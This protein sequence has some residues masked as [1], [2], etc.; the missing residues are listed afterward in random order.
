[1][2]R[3]LTATQ[4][5][6]GFELLPE[7]SVLIL[8]KN[9]IVIDVVNLSTAG[10]DVEKYE[11]ML[12]PGFVNCHC[13]LELSHMKGKVPKH[14]GL[15]DFLM[16]IVANRQATEEEIQLAIE[17][18]EAEMRQNGIVAVGDICN[19][20]HTIAQKLKG[21]LHY[22]NFIEVAGFPEEIADKRFNAILEVYHAFS[23][24]ST[25]NAIVP[26]AP[27]SV[28]TTLLEKI[29]SFSGNEIMTMHNQETQAEN[30]WYEKMEG[31]FLHFYQQLNI[32]VEGF[33]SL[34]RSSLQHFLP[35]FNLDQSLILVHNVC[36][37]EA[38]IGYA[39]TQYEKGNAALFFCLCPSANRYISNQLPDVNMFVRSGVNMVL[40]T[41]SLAS[42]DGLSIWEEIK[43]LQESFPEISVI[44]MLRWATING[45]RALKISDRYGSFEKGKQPGVVLIGEQLKVLEPGG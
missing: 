32:P 8:D 15:I 17:T 16:N 39:Q 18:A 2:Y 38:D 21:H 1:L 20:T 11:G 31:D 33:T 23:K 26:H 44:E 41:D 30:E 45:A 37:S 9:G 5:F 29:T 13:H 36:T 28:S 12:S 35:Y 19:T 27:Y 14:T 43:V 4:I 40:G 3:K 10:D 42:N 25:H 22:Q 6:N 34:G 24:I 7:G